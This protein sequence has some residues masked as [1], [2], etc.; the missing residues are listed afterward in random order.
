LCGCD[1]ASQAPGKGEFDR[2]IGGLGADRFILGDS[3]RPYYLGNGMSD[4][5]IITDFERGDSIVVYGSDSDYSLTPDDGGIDITYQGDR[6]A[7]VPNVS[8]LNLSTDFTFV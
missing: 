3:D 4:L 8:E 7:F 5:A 6:I 2:L 1:A